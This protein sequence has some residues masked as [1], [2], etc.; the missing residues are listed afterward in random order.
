M[1]S[2]WGRCDVFGLMST[3]AIHSQLGVLKAAETMSLKPGFYLRFVRHANGRGNVGETSVYYGIILYLAQL[4]NIHCLVHRISLLHL[5]LHLHLSSP[6]PSMHT[7][8]APIYKTI[9]PRTLS[10][11]LPPSCCKR[12]AHKHMPTLTRT[13]FARYARSLSHV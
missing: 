5:H 2:I 12:L 11:S 10:R 7:N 13:P 4:S 9:L 1:Y 6:S 3:A 8:V